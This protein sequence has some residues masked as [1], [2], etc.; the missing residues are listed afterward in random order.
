MHFNNLG[1]LLLVMA[2]LWLYFTFAEYLTTWYAHEPNELAVFNAKMSGPFAPFFWTMFVC[3]FVVPFTILANPHTRTITGT[4]VASIFVNIGMWLER[5]TIVVP[6]LSNP[7]A[8]V[9]DVRLLA[10]LGRVVADGGLLR[11]VRA[12]LHGIHEAVSDHLDL[13][14]GAA[15]P[16]EHEPAAVAR[17]PR[18][19][20][21]DDD[22]SLAAR[23]AR[24]RWSCGRGRVRRRAAAASRTSRSR[25]RS[26][27]PT[28][29]PPARASSS[30][31]NCV[32]CHALGGEEA[33][34]GPDLGRMHFRGTVLDL[35]GVFWNHAPV[36][37]EKMQDLK[38]VAPHLDAARWPI[39]SPF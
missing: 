3:C 8:P 31:K 38:I 32:R 20:R 28:T 10:E 2:C 5:F 35:A 14:A 33:R 16:Q 21:P 15:A 19:R 26:S 7:R 25:C 39:S 17:A 37:R 13:G 24:H 1:L 22:A 34:V 12:A 6:S 27:C 11:G 36:M 23:D 4:L 29:R 30:Q 9:H 18:R